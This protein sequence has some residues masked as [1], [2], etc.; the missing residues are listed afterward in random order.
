MMVQV[1]HFQKGTLLCYFSITATIVALRCQMFLKIQSA[2]LKSQQMPFILNNQTQVFKRQR[3][4]L[5]LNS[6]ILPVSVQ[7]WKKGLNLN[8]GLKPRLAPRWRPARKGHKRHVCQST[9][10]E[11]R[12]I[13]LILR[14]FFVQ[15]KYIKTLMLLTVLSVTLFHWVEIVRGASYRYLW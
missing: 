9:K 13:V 14:C 7:L 4:I 2:I 1:F 15:T 12:Q 5:S 8:L 10:G 11:M 3:N 6:C